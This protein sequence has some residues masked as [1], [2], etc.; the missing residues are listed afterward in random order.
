[1]FEQKYGMGTSDGE[2]LVLWDINKIVAAVE[3]SNIPVKYI[4]V[5]ELSDANAFNGDIEYAM[6]TDTNKPCIIVVFN[7][8][9]Q[10]LIDGNHRLCKAKITKQETIPCYI[11]PEEY[12]IKFI[13][14]FDIERYNKVVSENYE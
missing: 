6:T 11:L 5:K 1:M 8:K 2:N 7:G 4:D 9:G 13:V 3:S 10:K 12:H 14:E